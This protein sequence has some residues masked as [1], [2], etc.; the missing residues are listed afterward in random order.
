[1]VRCLAGRQSLIWCTFRYIVFRYI[2]KHALCCTP[3]YVISTLS[4]QSWGKIVE[5]IPRVVYFLNLHSPNFSYRYI[6]QI[7]I[8]FEPNFPG[9]NATYTISI[10]PIYKNKCKDKLSYTLCE[11]IETP[12]SVEI[13]F[14]VKITFS[15][16]YLNKGSNCKIDN[17]NK[18][19]YHFH[20]ACTDKRFVFLFHAW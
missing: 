4:R 19:I 11:E 3:D 12:K 8:I 9:C 6:Q 18:L 5:I 15:L 7:C 1:M 14:S 16:V 20:I 13:M 10:F 2:F 17:N